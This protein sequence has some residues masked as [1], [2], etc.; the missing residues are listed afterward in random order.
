L[1]EADLRARTGASV[2]VIM[3]AGQ[4]LPNPKS[5]TRFMADDLIGVI[6]DNAQV[7]R[8]DEILADSPDNIPE[9]GQQQVEQSAEPVAAPGLT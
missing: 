5:S 6:G 1:V 4:T 9:A 7:A 8:L 2:I 3:R